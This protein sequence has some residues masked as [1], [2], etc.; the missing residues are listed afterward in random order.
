MSLVYQFFFGTHV[1]TYIGC[2]TKIR[3]KL[4]PLLTATGPT[5]HVEDCTIDLEQ[6]AWRLCIYCHDVL[7]H[8][9]VAPFD[10]VVPMW[11]FSEKFEMVYIFY[12]LFGF[13]TRKVNS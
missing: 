5:G 12:V 9:Y 1:Y 2:T 13:R 10:A 4:V 7:I 8:E 3:K 6:K 11:A